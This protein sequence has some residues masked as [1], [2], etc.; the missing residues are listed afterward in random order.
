MSDRFW[1]GGTGNT[2]DTAHWSTTS[3]GVGGAS[4]PT[5]ADNVYFDANSFTAE[6][7]TVTVNAVMNCLDMD[8]TGATNEPSFTN[9]GYEQ[10]IYGN[11]MLT[12]SMNIIGA[13]GGLFHFY[14]ATTGK[15]ITTAGKTC[16]LMN[17]RSGA[18]GWTFQDN[19]TITGDLMCRNGSID[20]N[21][22]SINCKRLFADGVNA[23][24]LSL[25]S[26]IITCSDNVVFSSTGLTLTAN[27]S[28]IVLTG[29]SKTFHGGGVTYNNVEFQGNN[30]TITG[31]NTFN[32]LKIKAGNTVN[33][34]AGTT[35]TASKICSDTPGSPA[36]LS[37]A[38]GTVQVTGATIQDITAT[39]G[40]T[41]NAID[42]T[43]VSGNTGWNWLTRLKQMAMSMGMSMGMGL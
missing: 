13:Y 35:Q 19:V 21:G 12:S 43:N 23:R 28:T 30:C 7:Q 27:T 9:T 10:N 20:T 31:S 38:S 18:G 29:D 3:G 26:S 24:T 37:C 22:K 5:S 25:D 4:L 1:V 33:M 32:E 15:T 14:A 16:Y 39:G 34:T 8:W 6:G 41:F 36:T 42:C 11:V 2:S 40:A 17:F